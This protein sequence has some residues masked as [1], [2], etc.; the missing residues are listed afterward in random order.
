[1]PNAD[2][3]LKKRMLDKHRDLKMKEAEMETNKEKKLEE[4]AEKQREKAVKWVSRGIAPSMGKRHETK[5]DRLEHE[6]H[7][8]HMKAE[9]YKL[10]AKSLELERKSYDPPKE[11]KKT[12]ARPG[13][14]GSKSAAASKTTE[15][16]K[17]GDKKTETTTIKKDAPA[18]QEK[19]S[20]PIVQ[21]K[22]VEQT[23]HIPQTGS[24][25]A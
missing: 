21:E 14:A 19:K 8:H 9:S 3:E 2:T 1:M 5:A 25:T 4:K 10:E 16:K 17:D 23:Q 7:E 18:A 6:A 15:L 22:K 20:E 13:M 11:E 12:P 24:S